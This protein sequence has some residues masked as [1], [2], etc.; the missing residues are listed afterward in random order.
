MLALALWVRGQLLTDRQ[1]LA[2]FCQSTRGGELW[3]RTLERA[4][5]RGFDF[6]LASNSAQSRVEYLAI[7]D[8]FGTGLGCRIT[9]EKGRV[10]ATSFGDTGPR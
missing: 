10:V 5:E 7:V 3:A 8:A 6:V 2:G 4:H 9:V 1:A